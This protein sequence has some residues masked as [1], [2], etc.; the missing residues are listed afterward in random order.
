MQVRTLPEQPPSTA[1]KRWAR[2]AHCC[3]AARASLSIHLVRSS[4]GKAYFAYEA[5][6][7]G[8]E[9]RRGRKAP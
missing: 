2:P 8:F 1:S 6:G 7:R 4:E 3:L 5:G 9:S